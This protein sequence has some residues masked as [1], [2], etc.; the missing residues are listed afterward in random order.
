AR[1]SRRAGAAPA[2]AARSGV[3]PGVAP[4]VVPVLGRLVAELERERDQD[5]ERPARPG[6]S[7]VLAL[8]ERRRLPRLRRRIHRHDTCTYE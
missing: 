8:R 7:R 2:P 4:G 6:G 5:R 3:V 1:L